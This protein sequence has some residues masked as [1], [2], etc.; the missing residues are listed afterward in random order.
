MY[1]HPVFWG[2]CEG[3]TEREKNLGRSGD[4]NRWWNSVRNTREKNNRHLLVKPNLVPPSHSSRVQLTELLRQ[5]LGRIHSI[6][7]TKL[8]CWECDRR[9]EIAFIRQIYLYTVKDGQNSF[10]NKDSFRSCHQPKF[11]ILLGHDFY[12]EMRNISQLWI[13]WFRSFSCVHW[14][15]WGVMTWSSGTP[16][17]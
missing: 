12:S 13:M 15:W 5:R 8:Y 11:Q 4:E 9:S 6:S 7:S 14:P 3:L 16:V 1:A 2:L 17:D 10:Y